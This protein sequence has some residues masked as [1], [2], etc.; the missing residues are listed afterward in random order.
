EAI[1]SFDTVPRGD[2]ND[3]TLNGEKA[4]KLLR[5]YG[6]SFDDVKKYINGIKFAHVV[7][8]NKRDNIPDVLVKDLS[9]MLGLDPVT[10]VTTNTF[11]KL[12]LP[13]NGGG[14]FS[15]TSVNYTQQ[16]IDIELYRR[17]IL[18][19]AWLWKSKGTRKA[20]EFLFRFI[21]A[22]ESLVNFNEYIVM[23][24]KP[25]D[26]DEIK[27]LLYLYTGEVSDN[28]LSNIPYDD[29]GYPLPPIDGEIVVTDF[30]DPATGE[31]V[32]GGLTDMYFQKA[33]GWYR[34]TYGGPGLTVLRGNNPHI[35]QYD[36]GNEYLHYFS[37]CYIP[38]FNS[39][40]TVIVT[41]DTI[42]KNYFINYNYG[43]FNGIPTGTTEFYTT[44]LTYNSLTNGYQPIDDCVDV[45]YSIIETPIPNDG[46]TTFQQQ[47]GQA[48]QEYEDFQAQIQENSYL[49][50]SPEWQV[51]KNN[52]ELAQNNCLLEVST[53]N[54]DTNNTLEICINELVKDVIPFNCNTLSAVTDCTPFMYYVNEEGNKVTFDEFGGREGCCE[55]F[56]IG[57][58]SHVTYVNESGVRSEF[59]SAAAPCIGEFDSILGGSNII[60]WNITNN[61]L[62]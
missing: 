40:P 57:Q 19:I 5:I 21:G 35:G 52:Y 43:I 36:G 46:K 28:D 14:E 54:C 47:F 29:N 4:T 3:L 9:H 11:N 30:I 62:P 23:V 15:G 59:C 60:V 61:N 8:Y 39:D 12:L 27:K 24:D 25:L 10:F 41:A 51:I 42:T 17:L 56:G 37:R 18:N 6:V 45:N 34:E 31:F 53:E 50:Y 55:T 1:N 49:Q 38:N 22:P 58:Y 7:T 44:Q 32:Q 26:M 2:G 48:E 16:Q 20:V 13:S 33:G